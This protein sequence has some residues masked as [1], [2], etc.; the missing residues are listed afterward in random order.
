M[1]MATAEISVLPIGR[2]GASVGDV[3]A[4]LRKHLESQDKVEFRMGGM[5]TSL[6]GD[7]DDI[8]ALCAELHKIPLREGVPRAYTV[9]KIDQRTDKAGQ[10]L[11]DKVKSVEQKV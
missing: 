7:I 8:F 6:E 4:E 3:I 1:G 9:I 5:G 10:S 11:D 2:E